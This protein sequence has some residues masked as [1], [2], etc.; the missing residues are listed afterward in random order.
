M[1][2]L[3]GPESLPQSRGSIQHEVHL[4]LHADVLS[5]LQVVEPF[6]AP[7][8]SEQ[9]TP[10]ALRHVQDLVCWDLGSSHSNCAVVPHDPLS[11]Q[12][13]MACDVEGLSKCSRVS[14]ESLEA[15]SDHP[16]FTGLLTFCCSVMSVH[17]Y[18]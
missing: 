11:M 3:C 6:A 1:R 7:P 8:R 17:V 2:S 5:R 10:F 13:L 15:S 16:F 12:S 9:K 14:C 4:H 18:S